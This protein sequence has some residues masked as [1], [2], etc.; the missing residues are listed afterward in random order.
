M[1][2]AE[3]QLESAASE[4]LHVHLN[5]W[6][7][8][9]ILECA[10][11]PEDART[12][13]L[14]QALA[15]QNKLVITEHRHGLTIETTSFVGRIRVGNLDITI[16]PK[17]PQLPLMRLLRYAY[18]LRQVSS[19]AQT[20]FEAT[21]QTFQ[22]LLIQQLAVEVEDLL[23]RGLHREYIRLE[24]NLSIPRGR[25]NMGA[26]ARSG[27]LTAAVLPCTFHQRQENI[28]LNRVLISGLSLATRLTADVPLR[29]RLRRIAG[30]LGETI[31]PVHLDSHV[32]AMSK[33]AMNR[34]T[35][36][37]QPAILLIALLWEN[38]GLTL[39]GQASQIPLPGFLFDMNRF[40][41]AL[42][43]RFLSEN[44]PEHRVE[45][46]HRLRQVFRYNSQYNPRHQCAPTPRPDYA[47]WKGQS[48][49]AILDAKYRD[50]WKTALPP[51]WLYQLSIYALSQP[52]ERTAAI[53]YPAMESAA[54]EARIDIYEPTRGHSDS[55]VIL[56]PVPMLR[57]DAALTSNA[58]AAHRERRA[59]ASWMAFGCAG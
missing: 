34:L 19:F 6:E 10:A 39:D 9:E 41:Q 26:I 42:L 58:V 45:Q 5:E 36:R 35:S 16:Q 53:L 54:S 56:R 12:Q 37:Y 59:L 52:A 51:E 14:L 21:A 38:Q 43:F 49:A 57:L 28:L 29:A 40:F 4:L 7:T 15:H 20:D 1:V 18:G 48:L 32:F 47:I 3:Y 55:R 17:I 13:I 8:C 22:D 31:T 27:V 11:L 24:E 46:E 33:L 44:L 50:L 25:I 2:K 23:S 30:I